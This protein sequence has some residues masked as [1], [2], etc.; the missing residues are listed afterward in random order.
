MK[1]MFQIFWNAPGGKPV[2]VVLSMLLASVCEML[3]MGAIVPLV[4]QANAGDGGANSTVTILLKRIF[5]TVGIEYSFTTLLLFLGSALILKSITAFLAMRY[6]AIS[7]ADVT[8]KL[9]MRLLSATTNARWSYFVNHRPGEVSAMVAT[10]ANAAG[11]AFL[12]VAFLVTNS[13]SGIGLLAAAAVISFKLVIVS[14]ISI[15]ALAYPLNFVLKLAGESGKRQFKISTELTSGVQDVMS[16]MKPLK[17]M[18]RQQHFVEKFSTNI[19]N[20]RQALIRV[21]VS[22]HGVF[23]G[24]DIMGAIMLLVGIYVSI[25]VLRTPLSEML[26]VGIIF[27]QIVDLVKRM[28]LNL[29]NSTVAMQSY[30]GVMDTVVRAE[31][32]AE[33]DEGTI[34]PSLERAIRFEDVSFAYGKKMVLNHVNLECAANQITVFIGPSGA[35]KTTMVDLIIGFYL[36][37]KGR[38]TID[39]IDMKDVKLSAWRSKIG[40]VPQELTMLRGTIADNIRLGETAVSDEAII[41]ALRLAHALSFVE[42]LPDGINS[43]IGT[44][45]AKLSG[46]QRQR[47]SLA[48]ALVLKPKLLLLDEV[49]SALDDA[50]EAEICENIKL[51]AGQFTIVAI[52]HKS[53]WKLIADRIYNVSSGKVERVA[54]P[55]AT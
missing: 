14:I 22:Q 44:M 2:L 30:Y 45:G 34:E 50:S 21:M 52:T 47:L 29:Q 8:T 41:E 51:L 25:V 17:S 27:Y 16:N 13:I 42:A 37:Q 54:E 53:A 38:L 32:E 1:K 39:G 3:G 36:P 55:R 15:V 49:T 26:A 35:G 10:Q 23:H 20:L 18:A 6:V 33:I 40:Y 19:L 48:R 7:G 28:Q 12:S 9:R 11:E 43:D 31:A 24:Q 4:S 5:E 46:G